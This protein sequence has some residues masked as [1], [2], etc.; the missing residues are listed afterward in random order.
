MV[1]ALDFI[2]RVEQ[3]ETNIIIFELENK[4]DESKFLKTLADKNIRLS[5]MGN[6]KLRIVTHLDYTNE[7]HE[8]FLNELKGLKF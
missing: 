3:V 6:G 5:G 1:F 4:T 8:Y 2:K 7:M